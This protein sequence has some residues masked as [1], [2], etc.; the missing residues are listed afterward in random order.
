MNDD[1]IGHLYDTVEGV[2]KWVQNCERGIWNG[3]NVLGWK[4]TLKLILEV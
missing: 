4:R 3:Q 2:G 1:V